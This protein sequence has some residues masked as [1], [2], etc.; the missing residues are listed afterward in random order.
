MWAALVPQTV[1]TLPA[2]WETGVRSP[3]WE[4][5]LEEGMAT[6]LRIFAW[7][8]PMDRGDWWVTV[9]GVAESDTTEWLSLDWLRCQRWSPGHGEPRAHVCAQSCLILWPTGL[10]PARLL[11][12]WNFP[13]KNTGVGCHFFLQGIFPTHG[14]NPYHWVT[15][16]ALWI[17]KA[18][19]LTLCFGKGWIIP[20]LNYFLS[21]YREH[22]FSSQLD[23]PQFVLHAYSFF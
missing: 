2:M 6:Q 9:H 22:F 23:Y 18:R 20:K 16:K 4:D 17:C 11:C 3:S 10:W 13:G 12:P 1:K 21:H 19:S 7:R 15:W 14:S 8:I 5:P